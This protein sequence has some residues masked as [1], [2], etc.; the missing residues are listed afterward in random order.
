MSS[1]FQIGS[2]SS[3]PPLSKSFIVSVLRTVELRRVTLA[4][5]SPCAQVEQNLTW[6]QICAVPNSE[7]SAHHVLLETVQ[8]SSSGDLSSFHA[9]K[10]SSTNVVGGQQ[11][12]HAKCN[13]I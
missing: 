9:A 4:V 5:Y 3:T 2:A 10:K 13:C 11:N 1:L 12:L 8:H 6:G 7:R